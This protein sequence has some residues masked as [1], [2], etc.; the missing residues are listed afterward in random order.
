MQSQEP[1]VVCLA[2]SA[3]LSAMSS[4]DYEDAAAATAAAVGA[5]AVS[6]TCATALKELLPGAIF[7]R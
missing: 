6:S 7:L 2:H 5:Q 3:W 4:I 1:A